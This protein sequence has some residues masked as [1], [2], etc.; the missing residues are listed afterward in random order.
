VQTYTSRHLTDNSDVL[1]AFSGISSILAAALSSKL[2]NG[3]PENMLASGLLW[4][5]K[6]KQIRRLGVDGNPC[7][8]AWCWAGWVGDVVYPAVMRGT[9]R[10]ISGEVVFGAPSRIEIQRLTNSHTSNALP[11]YFGPIWFRARLMSCKI[12]VYQSGWDSDNEGCYHTI[13][14]NSLGQSCGVIF[15]SLLRSVDQDD[16]SIAAM[17]IDRSSHAELDLRM[18]YPITFPPCK[19][20]AGGLRRGRTLY[21]LLI[22]RL[23]N[24]FERVAVGKM[25]E[26]C[27][28]RKSKMEMVE[29]H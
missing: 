16:L 19:T 5:A 28:D 13:S 6:G 20:Y 17:G 27:F 7:Y 3:I 1:R 9:T 15:G 8:P 29:L 23:D 22:R 24:H 11:E 21:I 18:R 10:N 14:L 12:T 25:L 4:A 26:V 2:L